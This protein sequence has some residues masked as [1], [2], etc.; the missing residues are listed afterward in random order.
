MSKVNSYK[1]IVELPK[2]QTHVEKK[3]DKPKQLPLHLPEDFKAKIKE[4]AAVGDSI[5]ANLNNLLKAKATN[6]A[7]ALKQI[8]ELPKPNYADT[9]NNL[10]ESDRKAIHEKKLEDYNKKVAQIA[11]NAVKTSTPPKL[12]DFKGLPPKVAE[13][14]Y[15]D[16]LKT[17]KDQI[18]E[19]NKL[20]REAKQANLETN[21]E[22]KKLP[23][24][25]QQ[26]VKTQLEKN[27]SNPQ[28]VDTLVKLAQT[29][30]FNKLTKDEQ[31]K[32][33]TY[34]GGT[35]KEISDPARQALES[36]LNDPAFDSTKP[37][38]FRNFLKDQP[39]LAYVVSGTM[40]SGEFDSRR[41]PYTVTGPEEV[42]NHTFQSGKADADKYIVE[43]DGKKVP[44][45][46]AK[47]Q[48]ASLAYHTIEEVAK[49]LASLPK[50]SI[51]KVKSVLVDGKQ[52]P[53]DAY[54][55]KEYNT[56]GFRSYMTAG[57]DG[58]ISIYPQT[59][60]Q[61]Q[62]SI[63]A[64]LIHE[65]GH[66]LSKQKMGEDGGSFIGNVWRSI[67]GQQKWSEWD[68]AAKK[69]GVYASQYAK[70]SRDEDFAETLTLYMKVKGTPQE[71]EIRAI[72]PE[73]F[74]F[75]DTMLKK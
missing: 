54:W 52:N 42:K 73:R 56:P 53:D 10:P 23:A 11:D 2:V 68:A 60:K 21:A 75:L 72:M 39:G 20:S 31:T 51:D 18:T 29:E 19:L 48:D 26:L 15:R 36:K 38:S 35:N 13:L 45:Y 25:T 50:A 3:I 9:P 6:P 70:N 58:N 71:A 44:V 74:K 40:T 24:D 47:G 7:D 14:E 46:I 62:E 59:G 34:V 16:A 61:S 22:F 17:Y 41:K 28:A 63:D 43:V 4:F 49:G 67:T 1:P 12:E 5:K 32:F 27:Q 37:E 69:D 57:A 33:L 64:S 55:A 65:T 30:G 8:K 66:T